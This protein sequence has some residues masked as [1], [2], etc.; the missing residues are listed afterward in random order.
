MDR[1]DG[2]EQDVKEE[3]RGESM[4]K[5]RCEVKGDREWTG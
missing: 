2:M 3:G 4:D 5:I 1:V